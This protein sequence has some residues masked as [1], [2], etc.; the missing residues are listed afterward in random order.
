LCVLSNVTLMLAIPIGLVVLRQP[1][2]TSGQRHE[3]Q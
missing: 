2:T 1:V 3:T